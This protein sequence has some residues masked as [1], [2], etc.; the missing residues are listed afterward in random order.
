M[1]RPQPVP[2]Q[3][4]QEDVFSGMHVEVTVGIGGHLD[5]LPPQELLM[6]EKRGIR[7]SVT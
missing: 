7:S 6:I 3:L 2:V 4:L 1:C 5:E